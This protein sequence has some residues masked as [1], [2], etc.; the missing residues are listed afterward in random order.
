MRSIKLLYDIDQE[1][2]HEQLAGDAF[3]AAMA[4]YAAEGQPLEAAGSMA[5]AAAALA[6]TRLS[7]QDSLPRSDDT[8]SMIRPDKNR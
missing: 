8:Q 4:V 3:T 6:V 2:R 5:N 7:A 1:I